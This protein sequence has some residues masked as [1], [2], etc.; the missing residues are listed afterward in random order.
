MPII[1][2]TIPMVTDRLDFFPDGVFD[3]AIFPVPGTQ[4]NPP[5]IL[6]MENV[7]PTSRGFR[8]AAIE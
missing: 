8:N 3:T 1:D 7:V 2:A 4:E 5:K 6:H